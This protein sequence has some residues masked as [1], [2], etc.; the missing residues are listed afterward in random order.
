MHGVGAGRRHLL[1]SRA[2]HFE[3][4]VF[5]PTDVTSIAPHNDICRKIFTRLKCNNFLLICVGHAPGFST[6]LE[7]L[8]GSELDFSPLKSEFLLNTIYKHSVCTSQEIYYVTAAKTNR[9][10]VFEEKIGVYCEN[11]T[12]HTDTFCGHNTEFMYVKAAGTCNN[13]WAL[14]RFYLGML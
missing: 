2:I 8:P 4:A 12:K 13:H 6:D 7:R 10:M 1:C 14:K 5:I 11:H 3:E 9:L